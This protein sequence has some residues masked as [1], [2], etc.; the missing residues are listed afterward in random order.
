VVFIIKKTCKGMNHYDND[1]QVKII[2]GCTLL[3]NY[4]WEYQR[5]DEFFMVYEH[6][7]IDVNDIDQ[8]MT[9]NNNVGSSSQSYDQEMQ[10]QCK[11][12]ILMCVPDICDWLRTYFSVVCHMLSVIVNFIL[13]LIAY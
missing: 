13:L 10:V 9:Q 2:I 4:L 7:N 6:E 12:I 3:H 5:S 11:E 1:T 8:Q